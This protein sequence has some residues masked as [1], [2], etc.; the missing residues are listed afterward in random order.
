MLG[1]QNKSIQSPIVFLDFFKQLPCL[2]ED[3]KGSERQL[4][5]HQQVT[6]HPESQ[7]SLLYNCISATIA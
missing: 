5:D 3:L 6:D 4:P 2:A 7:L 1:P